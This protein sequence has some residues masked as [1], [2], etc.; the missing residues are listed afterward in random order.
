ME[1]DIIAL[2]VLSSP[3]SILAETTAVG[4][5]N[6]RFN[7]ANIEVN[8]YVAYEYQRI[9]YFI[10]S[11]LASSVNP[12]CKPYAVLNGPDPSV[13]NPF[14]FPASTPIPLNEQPTLP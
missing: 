13:L 6:G 9:S 8:T 14:Y 3:R 5:Q 2:S 7:P 1:G 10:R 12:K 11:N 4:Y